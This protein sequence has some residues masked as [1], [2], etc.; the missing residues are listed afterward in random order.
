MQGSFLGSSEGAGTKMEKDWD[1]RKD[2][3]FSVLCRLHGQVNSQ[4]G[5]SDWTRR[6]G[7]SDNSNST[8][9]NQRQLGEQGPWAAQSS[10][11]H[12]QL[13]QSYWVSRADLPNLLIDCFFGKDILRSRGT[14][15]AATLQA[16]PRGLSWCTVGTG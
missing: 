15:P 16:P 12:L 3:G 6:E 13:T 2:L 10:W 7:L 1:P 4:E 5:E 9:S 8:P 14:S 11:A